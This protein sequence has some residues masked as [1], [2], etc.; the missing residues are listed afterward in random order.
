MNTSDNKRAVTELFNKAH[1]LFQKKQYEQAIEYYSEILRID[2]HHHGAMVGIGTAYE[3][4]GEFQTAHS[5]NKKLINQYPDDA[6]ALSRTVNNLIVIENFEEAD[7]L[8]SNYLAKNPHNTKLVYERVYLLSEHMKKYSDA[9]TVLDALLS[10]TENY[11]GAL[12]YKS[13]LRFKAEDFRQALSWGEKAIACAHE[14][15]DDLSESMAWNNKGCAAEN[16][17]LREEAKNCYIKAS[18]D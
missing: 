1:S 5:Y 7:Q 9:E 8:L 6:D 16:L 10:I 4:L 14:N 11:A 12:V 15:K 2:P 3:N 13:Y 18:G 17:G